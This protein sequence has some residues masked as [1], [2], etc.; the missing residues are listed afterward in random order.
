MEKK[1]SLD[2]SFVHWP[3]LI[4]GQPKPT[5]ANYGRLYSSEHEAENGDASIQFAAIKKQSYDVWNLQP[6]S[7]FLDPKLIFDDFWEEIYQ[8]KKSTDFAFFFLVSSE[9]FRR[10][11]M[12]GF[13]IFCSLLRMSPHPCFS[14]T[15]LSQFEDWHGS[16]PFA[17]ILSGE[18]FVHGRKWQDEMYRKMQTW[19]PQSAEMYF[20]LWCKAN[21]TLIVKFAFRNLKG[22]DIHRYMHSFWYWEPNSIKCYASYPERFQCCRISTI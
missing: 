19:N 6:N 18:N 4:V 21:S 11:S 8:K 15:P 5:I 14:E 1:Q 16:G 7:S 13:A 9:G 3:M 17:V 12:Q 22:I 20:L 2:L 10:F